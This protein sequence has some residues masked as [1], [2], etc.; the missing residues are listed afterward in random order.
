MATGNNRRWKR[1]RGRGTCCD[2]KVCNK[3]VNDADVEF[4][5]EH[6]YKKVRDAVYTIVK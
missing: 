1:E 4:L 6:S 3:V 2:Y 5:P